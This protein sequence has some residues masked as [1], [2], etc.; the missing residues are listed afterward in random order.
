MSRFYNWFYKKTPVKDNTSFD[1]IQPI[2]IKSMAQ[3]MS[4]TPF[5][6]NNVS[7]TQG[8]ILKSPLSDDT[9]ISYLA[10]EKAVVAKTAL[11]GVNMMNRMYKDYGARETP[12]DLYYNVY[13][14]GEP[15]GGKKK[16][17]KKRKTKRVIKRK[18]KTKKHY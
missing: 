8:A 5:Y 1:D 16:K 15:F 18:N 7:Y 14:V 9:K 11:T 13:K 12:K 2:T 6:K 4:K 17:T 10:P 3:D